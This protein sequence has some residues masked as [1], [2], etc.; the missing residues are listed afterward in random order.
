MSDPRTRIAALLLAAVTA[1]IGWWAWKQGAYFGPV[2]YP[3]AFVVF[4][5][6][7]LLLAFA[8]LAV[9]LGGPARVALPALVAL[10]AWILLSGLWSPAPAAAFSYG[11]HAFLYVAVFALGL[12]TT[13]LL[14]GRML[15]A[16][17]PI[18]IA[19]ALV[20]IATVVALA[21]GTDPT[22]Y[23]HSDATLRFPIGYRNANAAFFLICLW[24][25]LALA[26]E[27]DWRWQ[28]RALA[29]GAGTVLIELAFLSQ[30]RGSIPGAVLALLVYLILSPKRL[31]A[32][33]VLSLMALPALL[34]IPTLL[35]VYRHGTDNAAVIPL[36][37]DSAKAI[38]ATG[39]LSLLVA[40]L[41]LGGIA[42][43]LRLR[44]RTVASISRVAAVAAL[45]VVL[46]GGA[47]FVS[48][49]GGP[50]GFV[51]QRVQEFDKV[52]YPDLRG[53]GIR[54]G[55]NVGSNRHDFWRVSIDEGRANPLFGGGAGAFKSVYLQHRLSDESPEDPHSMEALMLSELG[56]PGLLLLATFVVAAALAGLRSRRLG[57]LAA[58]LVAGALAGATQWF[59]QGSFD[60]LWNYPGITAP[61]MFLLGVAAA[62]ALLDPFATR[63]T[64]PRALAVVALIGLA[65]LVVP[66]FL[67]DRFAQRG[68]DE[69][70]AEPQAAISDLERA[71]ELNPFEA[72][73]LLSKGAIELKL[74]ETGQALTA[75]H[76][77]ARR[78]PDNYAA[79]YYLASAQAASDPAAAR[80]AIRKAR[81]LNPSEPGIVALWRRL[82]ETPA[83]G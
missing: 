46:V 48:R 29:V 2:F 62:P 81:D 61:A 63:S 69:S 3:G 64:R 26:A 55:A 58:G 16:L 7:A 6:L 60:W 59:V 70:R 35:D 11:A 13:N 18:A 22:W 75:F 32:A 71:A 25:T 56:F 43:R 39:L 21:T 65:L 82:E 10:S 23:L 37:R 30:S 15:L 53:Q 9:R 47:V 17:T 1:L 66:L 50:I 33:V 36:L 12:W 57:P 74:G 4:G 41:A 45:L 28:L 67:A 73:P 49:H 78:E 79:Y 51:N 44:E 72:T 27:S 5:L 77:A 8:P 34:A 83:Q 20:A 42:P 80:V 38:A 76:E 24:S 19:G 52:G 31:R 68:Y 14:A 40:G 54:Y